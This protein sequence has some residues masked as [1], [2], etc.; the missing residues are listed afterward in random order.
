MSLSRQIQKCISKKYN[1]FSSEIINCL[2]HTLTVQISSHFYLKLD[3]SSIS[4]T[5]DRMKA[6]NKTLTK[7][8]TYIGIYNFNKLYEKSLKPIEPNTV[9]FSYFKE[10][11]SLMIIYTNE[12]TG[13]Y[14]Y[15]YGRKAKIFKK[16]FT[17]T[18]NNILKEPN[19]LKST[20]RSSKEHTIALREIFYDKQYEEYNIDTVG[21][22]SCKPISNIILRKDIKDMLCNYLDNFE[23]AKNFFK[24]INVTYKLGIL[25]YG[26]P[27]TGKTSMAKAIAFYLSVPLYI[28]NLGDLNAKSVSYIKSNIGQNFLKII[29]F[30]DIDYIF[31]KRANERTPE[32]K[33]SSNAL[34]QLLD[35]A[36]NIS[37]T[38]FIATTNDLSSLDEALIRDGRFDLKIYM[39]NISKNLAEQMIRSYGITSE[40]VVKEILSKSMKQN[41][42]YNPANVQNNT[43]QYVFSHI[44]DLD[45]FACLRSEDNN[46]TQQSTTRI[47]PLPK[48]IN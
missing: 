17:N 26:P 44:E 12:T 47:R 7:I 22:I 6:F 8:N 5:P 20:T 36:Y 18:Y 21:Q 11:K 45:K 38:I 23:K 30:E 9:L 48:I 1:D 33:A 43:I 4:L 31:G 29:L 40:S 13:I 10:L 34:L 32:E 19:S 3:Y 42:M 39:D 28:I 41:Q 15:F 16:L 2:L 37:N 35:G 24:D 27:G 25:L 14:I 46:D